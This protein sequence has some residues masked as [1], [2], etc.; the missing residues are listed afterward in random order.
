MKTSQVV[1]VIGWVS[2]GLGFAIVF[3]IWILTD[4]NNAG[5]LAR[6]EGWMEAFAPIVLALFL[7]AIT[8]VLTGALL[9]YFDK[10]RVGTV[11]EGDSGAKG[12]VLKR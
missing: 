4:E 7:L 6:G 9:E 11:E 8:L 10:R 2:G 5:A 1:S 3:G 12:R